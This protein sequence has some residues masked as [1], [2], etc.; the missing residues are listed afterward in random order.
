MR[1][2]KL[3]AAGA[4]FAVT[5][6]ATTIAEAARSTVETKRDGRTYVTASNTRVAVLPKRGYVRVQ[7]PY[8]NVKV[9]TSAGHVR[10]R[11]PYYS[12]DISW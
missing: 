1:R 12:G 10:I 7:A 2:S 9:D 8:T 11:V 6:S 3:L 4:L 5:V